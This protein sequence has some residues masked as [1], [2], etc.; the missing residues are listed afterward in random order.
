LHLE[1]CVCAALPR[2]ETRTRVVVVMHR[3]EQ[4]RTTNTARL[5]L[6]C[7][8]NSRLVLYDPRVPKSEAVC[9]LPEPTPVLLFPAAGAVP[10]DR[11]LE[12]HPL[13]QTLVVPDGA[14]NQA[15]RMRRRL[16]ALA[17]LPCVSLPA[18]RPSAYRLRTADRRTR[19]STLEAIA[20]ALALLESPEIGAALE[21]VLAMMVD[22][23][24][25]LRGDLDG[26]RVTGGLPAGVRR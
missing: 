12:A 3:R 16:P 15:S 23:M 1:L 24:L 13:P 4:F 8:P 17:D 10:L 7:L 2:L 25:W 11:W 14:W 22:R 20:R 5:A 26:D 9:S 6:A 21:R 19:V 18:G